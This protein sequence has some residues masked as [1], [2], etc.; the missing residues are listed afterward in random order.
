ML[1]LTDPDVDLAAQAVQGGAEAVRGVVAEQQH[2][3][4]FVR[5]IRRDQG[6]N[7][8][9]GIAL[10]GAVDGVVLLAALPAVSA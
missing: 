9:D 6:R 7:G 3:R 2:V 4:R 10:L 5:L 8:F 1:G